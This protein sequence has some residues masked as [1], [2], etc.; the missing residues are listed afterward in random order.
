M[1]LIDFYNPHSFLEAPAFINGASECHYM[2][3]IP[4][5]N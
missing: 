2:Q 3:Y 5:S 4:Y 1:S